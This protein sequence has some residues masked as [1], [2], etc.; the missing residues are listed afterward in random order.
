MAFRKEVRGQVA[1]ATHAFEHEEE[2]GAVIALVQWGKGARIALCRAYVLL[3]R[4]PVH[5]WLPMIQCPTAL[6]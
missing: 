3:F 1:V 6:K 4:S 5:Q 2:D